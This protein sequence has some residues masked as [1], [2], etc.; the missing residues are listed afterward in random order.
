MC[1]SINS[2]DLIQDLATLYQ[3]LIQKILSYTPK[4]GDWFTAVEGLVFHRRDWD[5]PHKSFFFPPTISV[6]TQGHQDISLEKQEYRTKTGECIIFGT[7]VSCINYTTE[8][9]PE[10]PFLSISL[11]I[12]QRFASQL[13]SEISSTTFWKDCL[14]KVSVNQIDIHILKAFERLVDLLDTPDDIP[15]LAPLIIKEIYYRIFRGQQKNLLRQVY[16]P[17]HRND[18]ITRAILWLC[19]HFRET[20]FVENLAHQVNMAP[21]TFYRQFKEITQTSPIQFQKKLRLHEARRLIL[22][23]KKYATTAALSVGYENPKQFSR[24]YKRFFGRPPSHDVRKNAS[25]KNSQKKTKTD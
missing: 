10:K 15:Y 4:S 6:V 3:S 13:V 9:A 16:T 24:E 1:S 7:N 20:L 22:V 17:K 12:D 25:P 23:E 5:S 11:Q 18:Q 8:A 21:S 19:E 2:N 14:Q